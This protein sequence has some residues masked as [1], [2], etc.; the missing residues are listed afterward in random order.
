[1]LVGG[2]PEATAYKWDGVK[3]DMPSHRRKF[4][5]ARTF[6]CYKTFV[7]SRLSER[8]T[9]GYLRTNW[10]LRRNGKRCLAWVSRWGAVSGIATVRVASAT[11]AAAPKLRN[12]AL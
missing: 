12:A 11:V 10:L 1:M 8:G 3:H 4:L 7:K 2:L 5:L 6:V 9:T